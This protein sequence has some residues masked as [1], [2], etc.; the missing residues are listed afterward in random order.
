MCSQGNL[1][2][3]FCLLLP[4]SGSFGV[5]DTLNLEQL[6]APCAGKGRQVCLEMKKTVSLYIDPSIFKIRIYRVYFFCSYP[7]ITHS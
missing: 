2:V 5:V 6:G 4:P 7:E 1:L 3:S